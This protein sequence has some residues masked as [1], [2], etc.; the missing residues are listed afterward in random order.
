MKIRNHSVE[1]IEHEIRR[2][3]T[4]RPAAARSM[5]NLVA[6]GGWLVSKRPELLPKCGDD[7]FEYLARMLWD[8][9]EHDAVAA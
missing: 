9:V 8:C 6:F 4:Q 3:W 5:V 1:T 7:A 2:L